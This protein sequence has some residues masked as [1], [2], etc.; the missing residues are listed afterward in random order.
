[1]IKI[2]LNF[3]KLLT[4]LAGN[5]FGESE[6]NNQIKKVDYNSEYT[7]V[8]PERIK[9][10]ATSFIQGFFKNFVETIGIVGIEEKVTIQSSINNLKLI[11]V[12]SL[13]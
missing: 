9:Y 2:E 12:D 1:M 11:I 5:K 7:I 4:S 10:I 3:N 6:F 13:V 8:F